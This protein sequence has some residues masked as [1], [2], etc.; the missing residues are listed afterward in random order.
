MC[1]VHM[2]V[3]VIYVC[4]MCLHVSMHVFGY[5]PWCTYR[6][7]R[8]QPWISIFMFCFVVHC[9]ICQACGLASKLLEMLCLHLKL[10]YRQCDIIMCM[11]PHMDCLDS[12]N[13]KVGLHVWAIALSTELS[14]WPGSMRTC[15]QIPSIYVKSWQ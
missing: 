1:V 3:C 2:Y 14:S 6:E 7:F 10:H 9:G 12:G 15:V 4:C 13:T 8:G 5:M 11:Q